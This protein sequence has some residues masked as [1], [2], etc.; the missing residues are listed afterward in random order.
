MIESPKWLITRGDYKRAAFYLNRIAKANKKPAIISDTLL[1]SMI[2]KITK[3]NEEY[4]VFSLFSGRRLARNTI[5]LI[6]S[7]LDF[8]F[9]GN[10]RIFPDFSEVEQI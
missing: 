10:F 9:S 6:L 2:P 7:W 4:G 8:F 1:E 3:V 5:V